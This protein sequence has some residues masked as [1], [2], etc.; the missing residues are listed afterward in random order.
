MQQD[1]APNDKAIELPTKVE[2][3]A[4]PAASTAPLAPFASLLLPSST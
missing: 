3:T 2:P 4:L 1:L